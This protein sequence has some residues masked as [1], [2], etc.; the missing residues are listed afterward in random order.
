M[1]L[2]T[3]LIGILL[4]G[5]MFLIAQKNR[6]LSNKKAIFY[7]L[8][9]CLILAAPALSGFLD[10]AFM[11]A[12]YY[13]LSVVYL[14]LGCLDL[15]AMRRFIDGIEEKPYGVEFFCRF[16]VA[17]VGAALFSVVFNLCNELQYGIWA[18]TCL[19][20]FILPSLFMKAYE[21][22]L[23]VPP[24]VYNVWSHEDEAGE[25]ETEYLDDSRIIVVE[26]EIFRLLEDVKPLNIRVKAAE[27]VPFGVWFRMF[28][29]HY[30]AKSPTRPIVPRDAENSYGWMFYVNVF[31]IWKRSVDP[32][33]S[34]AENKIKDK[35]TIVAK[36]VKRTENE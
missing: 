6:L 32:A 8:A 3:P 2:L 16:V 9:A 21:A 30:N 28:V 14:L 31:W 15:Y 19:L 23:S 5:V 34:F 26:L 27:T 10:Y 11:P 13:F 18:S 33:L 1:Y 17:F 12:G 22:Y 36:R 7:L 25:I 29:R 35:K 20:P 24:E 4:G